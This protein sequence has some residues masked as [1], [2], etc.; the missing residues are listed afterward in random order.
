MD[1]EIE[2]FLNDADFEKM[3]SDLDLIEMETKTKERETTIRIVLESIVLTPIDPTTGESTVI[4][5]TAIESNKY[6]SIQISLLGSALHLYEI[7]LLSDSYKDD[8][9]IEDSIIG[10]IGYSESM[11][12]DT[13]KWLQASRQLLP[14]LEILET[15][16]TTDADLINQISEIDQIHQSELKYNFAANKRFRKAASE[17]LGQCYP[18]YHDEIDEVFKSVW[19]GAAVQSRQGWEGARSIYG[20][21]DHII[22][23]LNQDLLDELIQKTLDLAATFTDDNEEY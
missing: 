2:K 23:H 17:V 1:E 22:P 3:E 20:I 18:F 9:I 12:D 16:N 13:A 14:G 15:P 6:Y 8:P 11:G 4:G 7:G 21:G 19:G 5:Y 10:I